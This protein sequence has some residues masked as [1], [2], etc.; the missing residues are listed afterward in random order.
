MPALPIEFDPYNPIPNNPF[1]SPLSY[2]LQ[3]PTGPLVVGSGLSVSATGTI[4][5]SG[6]GGGGT[7]TAVTAGTGL[8]G[9]TITSTGTLSIANTGVVAGAYTYPALSVNAQ[10]Q[11]TSISSGNPVTSVG[12]NSP[13][14]ITGTPT[15]PTISIQLASTTQYGATQLNNSTSSTLTNQALT[16][17]AGKSLQDQINA[18]AQNANGLVLAGTLNASTGLV[19][20]ATTAGNSAGFTAGAVVPAATPAIN[21]YYLIV[22]TAAAS[23]TPTGGSAITGILVGDYILVSSGVWTILRVGPITGAY[24]TTTTDGVVQLATSAEVITGTDPNLVV[25]PFTGSAAYV[26]RKCFTG[27]GQILASNG[28]STYAALGSGID[29][30]V[31]T[32][33][34]SAPLGIKWAPGGGGGGATINM[35]F[36]APLSATANPYSGGVV[37]VSINAASTSACGAVQLADLTTTQ[38]GTSSTQAL[39]PLYTAQTYVS[40]TCFTAKGQVLV[41]TGSTPSACALTVGADGLALIACAA[42][43]LGVT[44]SSPIVTA[45]PSTFGAFKGY[46]AGA[47]SNLS[48]G[49]NSLQA[50]TTGAANTALGISAAQSLNSGCGNTAV[51]AG[52]LAFATTAC[53]NTAVGACA[54]YAETGGLFSTALGT[55]ALR[56]QNGGSQ[57]TAVGYE[58]GNSL[59]TGLANTMVGAVAGDNVTTGGCNVLLGVNSGLALTSTSNNVMVGTNSGCNST[60]GSNVFVGCGAGLNATSQSNQIVIGAGNSCTLGTANGGVTFAFGASTYLYAPS[61]SAV[62]TSASDARLKEEVADL[63]LGLDFINQIQPRTYQWKKNKEKAAGFVAQELQEIVVEHDAS[64]LGLVDAS[65]E[66]MGVAPAALIPVLVKAIQELSA[67]VAELK[68]KLG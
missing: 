62:W 14:L 12:V 4:S 46:A 25:T 3:G 26:A 37:G 1:Y 24:A 23:Y 35:S 36:S 56:A 49:S 5:A 66:Y 53:Y 29:G 63:A 57:N 20:T 47:G 43:T 22:T 51:G 30:Q 50:L 58:T 9:G 44:W 28:V 39:T 32:A 59:T 8:A 6:G 16:A 67:E 64:Y 48:V 18:L 31:L 40:Q 54:L 42:C 2:F 15:S 7:V 41:G 52:A 68:A 11:I 27:P 45:T 13:L 61:G 38:A 34:S 55:G 10:G 19:V 33:D 21:D 65:N 60:G 17:A